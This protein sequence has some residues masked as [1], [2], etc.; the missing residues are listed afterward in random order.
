MASPQTEIVPID[1]I[2]AAPSESVAEKTKTVQTTEKIEQV[3]NSNNDDLISNETTITTTTTTTATTNTT[4][5]QNLEQKQPQNVVESV[6]IVETKELKP[7]PEMANGDGHSIENN[8]TIE[9][10]NIDMTASMIQRRIRSEDE[11][12]AALAERRRKAR[13]EAERQAQLEKQREEEERQLQLKLQAEEEE[14]QRLF[15]L[16]AL[17]LVEEQRRS[18]EERLQKAIEE[19]QKREEEERARKETEEKARIEREEQEQKAR[20]EAERQKIEVAERLKREEKEREERRKRVEAIMSRTRAKTAAA[21]AANNAPN[22][23]CLYSFFSPST[24]Q[25]I[26]TLN[27]L[28]FYRAKM[29]HLSKHQIMNLRT[30]CQPITPHP[31]NQPIRIV[32]Q[33]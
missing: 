30:I 16:D 22:K 13:E 6:T 26:L 7:E 3:M 18:E 8:K 12:K 24:N 17:R 25:S 2:Q 31:S 4:E 10:E 27:Y 14:R 32:N 20:E 21:A 19:A 11:A 23:V 29:F 1:T 9:F 15:E 5:Q 33:L 28:N